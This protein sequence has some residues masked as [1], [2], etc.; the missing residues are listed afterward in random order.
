MPGVS[1]VL[2]TICCLRSGVDA[3][4]SQPVPAEAMLGVRMSTQLGFAQL[5]GQVSNVPA[6]P[7]PKLLVVIRSALLF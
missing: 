6:P 4:C 5:V 2:E 1:C 7:P 3:V